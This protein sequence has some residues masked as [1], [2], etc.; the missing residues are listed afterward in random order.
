[1]SQQHDARSASAAPDSYR[2]EIDGLRS[3]AV[4]AV[5]F[6]HARLAPFTGGYVGVDV[7]FVISGYLIA[8][9]IH[10]EVSGGRFTFFGFYERRARRIF[11]ALFFIAALC[12][13]PSLILQTPKQFK[14]FAQ[15]LIAVSTF[16]S[17]YFFYFKT[18]YFGTNAEEIPLL[19]AWSLSVEEQFYVLFPI[20]LLVIER[21]ARKRL[22]IVLGVLWIASFA[23][24]VHTETIDPQYNFFSATSRA[25]ELLSGALLAIKFDAMAWRRRVTEIGANLLSLLGIALVL[26]SVF[27]L[28]QSTPFPGF[29]ALAP[30]GGTVLLIGFAVPS[31]WVG[32]VLASAVPVFIGQ[33][34]Y[35]AYLWHQPL[36]AYARLASVD[37]P[38]AAVMLALIAVTIGLAYLSW[39][40]I[41]QPFRKRSNFSRR[42]IFAAS[43]VVSA[44]IVAFG[45]YGHLAK[46]FPGRFSVEQTAIAATATTSPLR[47]TCHTEGVNYLRP[48]SACRYFG[49]TVHWAVMGDSHVVELAYALA[50]DLKAKNEGVLHL[51]SSGCPPALLFE[52][53]TPG[54]T[55]WTKEAVAYLE[56]RRDI[57]QVILVYH[58]S[59]HLFGA[60]TNTYPTLPDEHPAFLNGEPA[61]QARDVYWQ[62]FEALIRRL[63]AAGKRVY[64]LDP[65]PEL[66]RH[67]EWYIYRRE[68]AGTS[69]QNSFG[70]DLDVYRRRNAFILAKLDTLKWD[71]NLVRVPSSDAFCEGKLCY[72][73]RN[74]VSLYFD[75]NHPSLSG[76]ARVVQ[77]IGKRAG[78]APH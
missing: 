29:Y 78:A 40:F 56:S 41:E 32:R 8:G 75:D 19:H 66:P 62:S 51:S 36:F 5:I 14:D 4:L 10:R 53:N 42:T 43:A 45:A 71:G 18:G 63:L 21:F 74:G 67:V 31:T 26:G 35:S 59:A 48:A 2:P 50:Q 6:Y 33:L 23:W 17:N 38:P 65:Y 77:L 68:P 3:I 44:A 39:R 64:V 60:M 16:V 57:T 72:A 9:I 1:M 76:A 28:D 47:D 73:V 69:R 58:H 27:L 61:P 24:C 46:G 22:G 11:P 20:V 34:S 7:F 13:V 49:K 52:S 55:A 15:S 37:R 25:W 30:I 54:C 12:I 70:P